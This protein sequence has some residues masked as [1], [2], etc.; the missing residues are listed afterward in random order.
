[1]DEQRVSEQNDG[2]AAKT[3]PDPRA[4]AAFSEFVE[5]LELIS[6][7]RPGVLLNTLSNVFAMRAVGNKTHGDL[8][9]IVELVC[10]KYGWT[11]H[12]VLQ[13][14]PAVQVAL[15]FRCWQQGPGGLKSGT[16]EMDEIA[17]E[18]GW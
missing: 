5:R 14:A 12:Y 7:D 4:Q 9:E 16:L 2:A 3:G 6:K 13:E 1:M 10:R 8:A 17:D 15:L 18:M 11:L